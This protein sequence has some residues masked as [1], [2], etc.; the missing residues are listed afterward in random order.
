MAISV[1]YYYDRLCGKH[2][3]Q[4]LLQYSVLNNKIHYII[5]NSVIIIS[6]KYGTARDFYI[7]SGKTVKSRQNTLNLAP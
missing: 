3:W 5:N 6:F 7:Y 1:T 2:L 4:C